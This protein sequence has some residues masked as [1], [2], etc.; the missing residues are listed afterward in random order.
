M[1]SENLSLTLESLMQS[2]TEQ[3]NTFAKVNTT[4][5][6]LSNTVYTQICTHITTKGQPCHQD[7]KMK[8]QN[9]KKTEVL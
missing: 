3:I 9:I 6:M 7:H 8:I 5:I 2:N 4:Y 1:L